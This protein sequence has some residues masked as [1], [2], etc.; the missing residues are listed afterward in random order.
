[1]GKALI[2]IHYLPSIEYFCLLLLHREIVIEKHENYQKQTYRNRCYINTANGTQ[3][4]TVPITEK[5]GKVLI[6]DARIDHSMNW[7]NTHWRAIL[8]AYGKSPFF[9]HYADELQDILYSKEIFLYDLDH[10][11]LSFCLQRLG[12]SIVLT[13]STEYQKTVLDEVTDFRSTITP[14]IPFFERSFYEPAPYIQVFGSKFVTNLSLMDLLFCEGPNA[15]HVLQSST[16]G[17][18]N[19]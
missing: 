5:H 11:L 4:L 15:I 8:S 9:E 10:K 19:K 7:V 13:E 17:Y 1:M 6:K 3:A 2:E 18:L 12:V 14:K 16:K